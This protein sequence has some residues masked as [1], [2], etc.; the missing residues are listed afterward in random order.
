M[1]KNFIVVWFGIFDIILYLVEKLTKMSGD[2]H[3]FWGAIIFRFHHQTY[4][5]IPTD[6]VHSA[7]TKAKTIYLS[8][9]PVTGVKFLNF[10]NA[11]L[12]SS[13]LSNPVQL[14][15]VSCQVQGARCK[16]QGTSQKLQGARCK[17]E[18]CKVN[19]IPESLFL[20]TIQ[21][22]NTI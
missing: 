9:Y 8:I 7:G 6:G 21:V 11:E 2:W 17:V 1:N 20:R 13:I 16:V 4:L 18:T 19:T 5:L 12:E 22:Y 3:I 14:S 10:L 15:V